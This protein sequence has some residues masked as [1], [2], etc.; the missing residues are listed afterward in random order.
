MAKGTWIALGILA[1]IALVAVG[2]AASGIGTYNALT[3]ESVGIDG[4]SKQVDVQYQRAFRLVPQIVNLSDKYVD[5]TSEAYARVTALRAGVDQA[6]NGTLAQ[7]EA[8]AQQI[9]PTFNFMVEA[10]PDIQFDAVYQQVIDEIVNTENKIAA[11]KVRYNDQVTAYNA[12]RK[13]CCMPILVASLFGFEE[14]EFI[15]FTDRP[16]QTGFP[17]DQQI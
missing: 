5:K 1:A 8:A 11:E 7:K 12:H 9:G 13:R 2:V 3:N 17:A 4:Q 15:G 14:R 6:Q 16:N 10:Y